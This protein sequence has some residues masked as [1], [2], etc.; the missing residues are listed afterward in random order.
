MLNDILPIR[1]RYQDRMNRIKKNSPKAWFLAARP[2]TLTGAA[3]P[4]I[5]AIATAWAS[6]EVVAWIPAV[7]CMLFALTTQVDANFVN[8]YSDFQHGVDT[9][10]RLGPEHAYFQGWIG[11]ILML[12][13]LFFHFKNYLRMIRIN[14]GRELRRESNKVLGN[15]SAAIFLF[16]ISVAIARL[17]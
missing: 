1:T 8:D 6:N 16:A 12:P 9:K 7:L 4:V 13:F 11:G 10:D 14:H 2:K 17:L 3:S 5:L 15:S